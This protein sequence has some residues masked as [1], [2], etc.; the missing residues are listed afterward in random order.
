M[1]KTRHKK[2]TDFARRNQQTE[3]PIWGIRTKKTVSRG[4]RGHPQRQN[5]QRRGR[6][7]K[8]TATTGTDIRRSNQKQKTALKR[9]ARRQSNGTGDTELYIFA[10][11]LAAV[12]TQRP[13]VPVPGGG[14]GE[15]GGR[16]PPITLLFAVERA[17]NGVATMPERPR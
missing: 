5:P 11:M 13:G 12:V 10:G 14:E 2:Q 15:L 4:R 3:K 8:T 1:T 16:R 6:K 9:K 17:L 7:A